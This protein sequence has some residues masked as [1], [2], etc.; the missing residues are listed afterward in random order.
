MITYLNKKQLAF[1]LDINQEDARAKMCSAWA[2]SK[3]EKQQGIWDP[4]KNHKIDD[5]YPVAMSIECFRSH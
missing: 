2:K 1:I 3:K 5:P 4:S